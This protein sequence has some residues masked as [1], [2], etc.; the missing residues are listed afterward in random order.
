MRSFKQHLTEN[1][2]LI[3]LVK[4]LI[5]SVPFKSVSVSDSGT[6]IITG[7]K[8]IKKASKAIKDIGKVV[9]NSKDTIEMDIE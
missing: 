3:N 8:D 7:I 6:I 2:E 9:S 5:P 4:G 1:K